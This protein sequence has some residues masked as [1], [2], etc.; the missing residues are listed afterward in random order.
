MKTKLVAIFIC[1]I[2]AFSIASS[3][4]TASA[5]H[6]SYSKQPSTPSGCKSVGGLP[7]SKCTP[8]AV[9]SRVTQQNIK[10]TICKPGYTK[11]VR[12]PVSYTEPLKIKIMKSYGIKGP[13]KDYELDHLIPLEVGGSPTDVKNLWPEPWH[14]N[15]T[16]AE[17]DK[18]ENYL[19]AQICSG[20][21]KLQEAQNEM[22]GNWFHYWD[23]AGR[24]N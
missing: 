22:A 2:I 19:H 3:V 5:R 8:G 20:N 10:N 6:F 24:K 4:P 17:K 7:D 14:G 21:M 12:P 11:T 23:Q 13:L 18:F 15:N 9:D 1:G 16:A